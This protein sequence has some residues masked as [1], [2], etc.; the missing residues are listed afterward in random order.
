[1]GRKKMTGTAGEKPPTTTHDWQRQ[2]TRPTNS[3][4][5]GPGQQV[6]CRWPR[7]AMYILP[8]I[9]GWCIDCRFSAWVDI[10]D[11]CVVFL[12]PE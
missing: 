11:R 8:V 12:R 10:S 6:S 5:N 2:T 9:L 4:W 1:M 3:Y 7:S